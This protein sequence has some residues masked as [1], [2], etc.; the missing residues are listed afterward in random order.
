MSSSSW[1]V[2]LRHPSPADLELWLEAQ[3][4]DGRVLTD[5]SLLS[6]LRMRF[7]ESAPARVRYAVERRAVPAPV[8]YF[9]FREAQGWEHVG[10]AADF[11]IWKRPYTGERPAG[12]IG[13]DL[14]RRASALAIGLG[15]I[16][17]LALA[18]ALALG[19]V[20][21]LAAFE[22]TNSVEFWA[23]AVAAAVV[24]VLAVTAGVVLAVSGRKASARTSPGETPTRER[25]EIGG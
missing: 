13:E 16:G 11:H 9:R 4:A 18:V 2:A 1:F 7:T 22:W 24:G 6:P 8:D 5:Y 23:P 15:V 19:A 14:G 17:V 3:A 21:G 10:Q 12:F 25:A 20:A